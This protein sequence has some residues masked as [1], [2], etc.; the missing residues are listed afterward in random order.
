MSNFEKGF[1]NKPSAKEWQILECEGIC[2]ST[3]S[4]WRGV[5]LL[6]GGDSRSLPFLKL[7]T[8]QPTALLMHVGRRVPGGHMLPQT[9]H[10]HLDLHAMN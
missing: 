5:T 4:L 10:F 7:R 3:S 8:P 6:S 9:G 1:S 2:C